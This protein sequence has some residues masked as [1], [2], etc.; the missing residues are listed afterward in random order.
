MTRNCPICDYEFKDGDDV[1]A[2]MVA[3]F[4]LIDSDTSYAI[5]HPTKCV[6]LVHSDCFDWEDYE[7]D[8]KVDSQS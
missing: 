8:D 2:V 3:K 6:E 7:D 5:D 4:K 1:V